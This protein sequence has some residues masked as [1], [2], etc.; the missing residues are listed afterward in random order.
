MIAPTDSLAHAA[1]KPRATTSQR[2]ISACVNIAGLPASGY[3]TII[4]VNTFRKL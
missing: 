3:A 4:F 1:C 2:F